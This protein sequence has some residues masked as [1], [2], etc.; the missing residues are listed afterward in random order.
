MAQTRGGK[1]F[2]SGWSESTKGWCDL[3][4]SWVVRV[5]FRLIWESGRRFVYHEQGPEGVVEEDD[6]GSQ[7]HGDAY[8]LVKLRGGQSVVS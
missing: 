3:L 4:A 2:W 7:K 6:R 1:R 5:V 8:K